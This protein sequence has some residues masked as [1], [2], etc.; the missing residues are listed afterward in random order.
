[1]FTLF[2]V[3]WQLSLK[4]HLGNLMDPLFKLEFFVLVGTMNMYLTWWMVSR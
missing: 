3:R 1:M 2:N 4:Y